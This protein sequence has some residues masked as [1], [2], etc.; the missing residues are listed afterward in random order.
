MTA[1]GAA[2]KGDK[3]KACIFL[4]VGEEA[5]QVYNTFVFDDCDEYKLK[6]NTREI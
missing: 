1:T 4:H 5:V 3:Q 6:K 2:E